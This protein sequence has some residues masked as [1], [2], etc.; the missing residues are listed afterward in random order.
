MVCQVKMAHQEREGLE[1][2]E[3]R[4][5]KAD[6]GRNSVILYFAIIEIVRDLWN[7][8]QGDPGSSGMPGLPGLPGEDGAP[9]QKVGWLTTYDAYMWQLMWLCDNI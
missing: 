4:W 5:V 2:L 6:I 7:C 1:T 3:P 8:P 9:G